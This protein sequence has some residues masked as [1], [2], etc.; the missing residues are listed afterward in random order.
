MRLGQVVGCFEEE[1]VGDESDAEQSDQE[2]PDK[3]T[4]KFCDFWF[5]FGFI[6]GLY[7]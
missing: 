4:Q 7:I 6:L 5:I 2:S 3:E 1:S